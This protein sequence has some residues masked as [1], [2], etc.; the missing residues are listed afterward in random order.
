MSERMPKDMSKR[1]S[2]DMSERMAQDMLEKM[3]K[4]MSERMSEDMP[5]RMSKDMSQ[6]M[7]GD[8]PEDIQERMSKDMSERMSEDMSKRMSEDMSEEMSED[9]SEIMSKD[10]SERMAKDMSERM[11]ER[12]VRRY[13][14]RKSVKSFV[15]KNGKRY[16]RKMSERMSKDMSERM[17]EDMS[18]RTSENMSQVYVHTQ[19]WITRIHVCT[20]GILWMASCFLFYLAYCSK[21]CWLNFVFVQGSEFGLEAMAEVVVEPPETIF[22]GTA[23][24]VAKGVE[25]VWRYK[26]TF[27]GA[28]RMYVCME[29]PS[30][31][32]A[33]DLMFIM[34]EV[35]EGN[36]W[37]VAYE[38]RPVP[39]AE[40]E[41]ELEKRAAIF[42][43]SASFWEDGVH[44]WETN[45]VRSR[46]TYAEPAQAPQWRASDFMVCT[47]HE[48]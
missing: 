4:D 1:M 38:G 24:Q 33:G 39:N 15:R 37:Y 32:H 21:C 22:I 35:V 48:M 36:K 19:I 14:I 3:S 13:V 16:V 42:R 47:R 26:L 20:N 8:I 27:V 46:A 43:T 11:S 6:R 2:G 7:S 31:T 23:N 9:M 12:Y 28:E 44:E 40:G 5:E 10:R 17:S 18:G 30:T 41:Q 29:P 45:N 25:H 34:E